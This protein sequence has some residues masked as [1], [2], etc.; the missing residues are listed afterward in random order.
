MSL[1]LQPTIGVGSTAVGNDQG[2]RGGGGVEY[3]AS[4]VDHSWTNGRLVQLSLPVAVVPSVITGNSIIAY[5][6]NAKLIVLCIG[7]LSPQMNSS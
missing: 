3:Q 2:G 5:Q 1:W 6:G 4:P 7:W